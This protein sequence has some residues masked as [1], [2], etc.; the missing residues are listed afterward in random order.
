MKIGL[1]YYYVKNGSCEGGKEDF[2]WRLTLKGPYKFV[3]TFLCQNNLK[4]SGFKS[5]YLN[6]KLWHHLD[7]CRLES[8]QSIKWNLIHEDK[9]L[10]ISCKKM[11]TS[12]VNIDL[13]KMEGNTDY[14]DQGYN[15]N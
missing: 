6:S 8:T 2:E 13:Y 9:T 11:K 12:L 7:T 15:K 3:Y 1:Q 10:T 14:I 5:I 4:R